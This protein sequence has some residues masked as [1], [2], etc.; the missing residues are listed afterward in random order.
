MKPELRIVLIGLALT[1]L[2]FAVLITLG[3]PFQEACN[4]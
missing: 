4:I 3:Q 1:A 2:V